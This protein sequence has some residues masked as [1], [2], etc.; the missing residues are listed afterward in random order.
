[1]VRLAAA[2]ATLWREALSIE[3][4]SVPRGSRAA[5]LVPLRS[6][7]ARPFVACWRHEAQMSDAS[8]PDHGA[9]GPSRSR[10]T[11]G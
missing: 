10:P 8:E 1:M 4:R 5:G 7:A 2:H 11:S 6:G 3:V 9:A